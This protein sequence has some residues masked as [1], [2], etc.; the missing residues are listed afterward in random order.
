M[1]TER[2]KMG[3]QEK[4]FLRVIGRV[5]GQKLEQRVVKNDHLNGQNDENGQIFM[6]GH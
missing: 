4:Y 5:S 6:A 2:I 3:V 1:G